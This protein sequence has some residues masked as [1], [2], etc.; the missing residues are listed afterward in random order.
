MPGSIGTP[1]LPEPVLNFGFKCFPVY[2]PTERDHILLTGILQINR[3]VLDGLQIKTSKYLFIRQRRVTYIEKGYVISL[4]GPCTACS[5][6]PITRIL[7]AIMKSQ[8]TSGA[9]VLVGN[10][11]WEVLKFFFLL[12]HTRILLS[13]QK[14]SHKEWWCKL[15]DMQVASFF[16]GAG[17]LDFGLRRAGFK[18]L[19]ANKYWP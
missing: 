19:W 5:A 16:A 17:G 4:R 15:W 6:W 18:I 3:C 12:R 10:T 9:V 13:I 2:L 8:G 11:D 1:S 7:T 14:Q